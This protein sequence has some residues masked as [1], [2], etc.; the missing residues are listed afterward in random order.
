ME[1]TAIRKI[2][3]INDEHA[4]RAGARRTYSVLTFGCQMNAH[5]S[6]KLEGMLTE[7]GYAKSD[8]WRGADF[9]LHNTCCI[10]ENAENKIYGSLGFFKRLKQTRPDVKVGLCGCMM[11]QDGAIAKIKKTYNCVDVIFGT[12]NLHRFPEL[13]LAHLETG[14]MMIDVWKEHEE[15][16]ENQ[17]FDGF[18]TSNPIAYKLEAAYSEDLPAIRE[19]RHKAAV[20]ITYGCNNFCSYC[21]VPYV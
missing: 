3:Q 18:S 14:E 8:D 20:N 2:R 5:D 1:K 4:E 21:I 13:L 7:M 16:P 12:F 9:V 19:Y 15:T 11:Q 10:R 6:E 17:P